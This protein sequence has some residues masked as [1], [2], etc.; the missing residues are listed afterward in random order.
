MLSFPEVTEVLRLLTMHL[1]PEAV[2]VT[3]EIHVVDGI[4]TDG[5]EDLLER[6]SK[7]IRQE[8]PEVAQTFI[9][10][11]PARQENRS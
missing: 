7:E 3:A 9:E 5:I 4:D 1:R 10:P 6:M 11:H 8:V 2:L